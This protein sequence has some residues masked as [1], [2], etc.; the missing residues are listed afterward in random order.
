MY[1]SRQTK[2][3]QNRGIDYKRLIISSPHL[4]DCSVPGVSLRSVSGFSTQS[5]STQLE[6]NP[7]LIPPHILQMSTDVGVVAEM[8]VTSGSELA[9]DRNSRIDV[10]TLG[11]S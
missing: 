6:M 9:R 5:H 10:S 8:R 3:E 1:D 4:D 2:A 11:P 7:Q